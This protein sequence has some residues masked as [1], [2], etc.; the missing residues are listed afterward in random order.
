MSSPRTVS[1]EF[2]IVESDPQ[3]IAKIKLLEEKNAALAA[4]A[5]ELT[6]QNTL[7]EKRV[8][9]VPTHQHLRTEVKLQVEK[10][11]TLEKQLAAMSVQQRQ[12][13]N[14]KQVMPAEVRARL[15]AEYQRQL[16]LSNELNALNLSIEKGEQTQKENLA[17]RVWFNF[18]TRKNIK[19]LQT[20]YPS[21]KVATQV[22]KQSSPAQLALTQQIVTKAAV[23][24]KTS[25]VATQREINQ[26]LLTLIGE[27]ESVDA[28]RATD[29]NTASQKFNA[30]HTEFNTRIAKPASQWQHTN[31]IIAKQQTELSSQL[32]KKVQLQTALALPQMLKLNDVHTFFGGNQPSQINL[33]TETAWHLLEANR[34]KECADFISTHKIKLNQVHPKYGVPMLIFT[35]FKNEHNFLAHC[36]VVFRALLKAGANPNARSTLPYT[37]EYRTL[38]PGSTVQH[39]FC[40]KWRVS[41]PNVSEEIRFLRT[42]FRPDINAVDQHKNSP[43]HVV[44]SFAITADIVFLRNEIGMD[45]S[46]VNEKGHTAQDISSTKSGSWEVSNLLAPTHPKVG[47]RN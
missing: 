17:A 28:Q 16:K 4:L 37:M 14:E 39:A 41:H 12:T 35:I 2:V 26:A 32:A 40:A 23:L 13:E 6:Q 15:E 10:I 29:L 43:L 19:K 7:L 20:S 9:S 5:A 30:W 36:P 33:D 24:T 21:V 8:A 11:E 44:A 3:L 46:L 22:F 25:T 1:P 42:S 31:K 38:Q 27:K 18:I 34:Y 45:S 47:H